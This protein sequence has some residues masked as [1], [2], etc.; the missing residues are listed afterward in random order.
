ME[1]T[2]HTPQRSAGAATRVG[3]VD[4]GRGS[5]R[6]LVADVR[7]GTL[8]EV[9]R[10]WTGKGRSG[11][12]EA[13]AASDEYA[14]AM[15]DRNCAVSEFVLTG[16]CHDEAEDSAVTAELSSRYEAPVRILDALAERKL[17]FEGAT[18]GI[19]LDQPTLFLDIGGNATH[20]MIA[21]H[22]R[23]EFGAV[24]RLGVRRQTEELLK[25]DPPQ[26]DEL[27]KLKQEAAWQVGLAQPDGPMPTCSRAI[28]V[29]DVPSWEDGALKMHLVEPSEG[30][31][32]NLTH[33]TCEWAIEGLSTMSAD[34]RAAIP[35][36][37]PARAGTVLTGAVILL[38]TMRRFRLDSVLVSRRD[39]LDGLALELSGA[40]A[41]GSM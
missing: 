1:A 11:G 14:Q 24:I 10:R 40:G 34:Q 12:S 30:A 32:F 8:E 33:E 25:H 36:L 3:V 26:S 39:L 2:T 37:D 9:D 5:T 20:L 35:G 7:G 31:G 28:A 22:G 19:P 13:F 18:L 41:A 15:L 4:V 23:V 17:T 38:E 29:L 21:R 16:G 27:R 6:M